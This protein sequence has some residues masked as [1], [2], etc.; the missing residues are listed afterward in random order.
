MSTT[1]E[2][3]LAIGLDE[4]K[5]KYDLF[6]D[7]FIAELGAENKKPAEE[8]TYDHRDELFYRCT[9]D[10]PYSF[11]EYD[12]GWFIGIKFKCEEEL[13]ELDL[14]EL[15]IVKSN[16]QEKLNELTKGE[17]LINFETRV[18]KHVY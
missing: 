1:Y 15:L 10:Y 17:N 11:G 16:F 14:D 2:A 18:I 7:K 12:N 9:G 6:K 4:S 3:C 8:L 5:I 13:S